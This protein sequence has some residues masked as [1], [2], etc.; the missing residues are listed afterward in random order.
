VKTMWLNQRITIRITRL[1]D[2]CLSDDSFA[3]DFLELCAFDIFS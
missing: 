1:N 3:P 2:G